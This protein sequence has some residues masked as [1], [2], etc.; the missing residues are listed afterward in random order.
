MIESD[1]FLEC[2]SMGILN[3]K[4]K[5]P[6]ILFQSKKNVPKVI[7]SMHTLGNYYY[8]N[9]HYYW[10]EQ[11]E[12]KMRVGNEKKMKIVFNLLNVCNQ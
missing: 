9:N 2:R 6:Y 4:P 5:N 10:I 12:L 3:R 11:I 7:A 8:N 1:D